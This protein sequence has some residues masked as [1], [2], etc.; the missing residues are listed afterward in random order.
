MEEVRLI[1]GSS[2]A[3]VDP[4]LQDRVNLLLGAL[5][6][7]HLRCRQP[8]RQDEFHPARKI[9][10]QLEEFMTQFLMEFAAHETVR[11]DIHHDRT[12]RRDQVKL[13]LV[14]Q[15]PNKVHRLLGHRANILLH[16]CRLEARHDHRALAQIFLHFGEAVEIVAEHLEEVGH[17]FA[18][19]E[20]LVGLLEHKAIVVGAEQDIHPPTAHFEREGVTFRLVARFEEPDRIFEE[21]CQVTQKWQ[22]ALKWRRGGKCS[23]HGRLLNSFDRRLAE[24]RCSA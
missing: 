12:K 8:E 22:T 9:T 14:S 4:I 15:F 11:G 2:T 1:E 16:D 7:D 18:N 20:Q 6:L 17:R 10:E 23:C 13:A 3:L 5:A 24:L 19:R 21:L